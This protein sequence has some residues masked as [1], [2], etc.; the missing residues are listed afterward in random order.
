MSEK[1]KSGFMCRNCLE[2]LRKKHLGRREEE[3]LSEFEARI[4]DDIPSDHL[5]FIK[6]FEKILY[7]DD[8]VSYEDRL[9][10]EENYTDLKRYLSGRRKIQNG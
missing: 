10:L 8:Q 6:K 9:M 4:H 2:L 5:Q 3:T 7:S 1:E